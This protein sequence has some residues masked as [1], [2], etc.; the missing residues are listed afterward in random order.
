MEGPNLDTVRASKLYTHIII[1]TRLVLYI[2]LYSLIYESLWSLCSGSKSKWKRNERSNYNC[3][4]CLRNSKNWNKNPL[5]GYL[6]TE[7][8][9]TFYFYKFWCLTI[10]WLIHSSLRRGLFS[11]MHDGSP[12]LH[13]I[14]NIWTPRSPSFAFGT[15]WKSLHASKATRRWRFL[16][17]CSCITWKIWDGLYI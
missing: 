4:C 8:K 5:S 12:F 9:E 17:T 16:R 7:I 2:Y 1:T 14:G 10:I 3:T 6:K 11:V 15:A 13:E